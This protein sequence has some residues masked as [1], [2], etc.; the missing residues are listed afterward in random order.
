[1]N[2]DA[3][4]LVC[5]KNVPAEY[6]GYAEPLCS[7]MCFEFVLLGAE[8]SGKV[9]AKVGATNAVLERARAALKQWPRSVF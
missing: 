7:K 2:F 4:C 1:M 5:G 9:H 3:R 6:E 8:R